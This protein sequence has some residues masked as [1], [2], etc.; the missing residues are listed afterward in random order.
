MRHIVVFGTFDTKGAEYAYLI[1]RIRE[2]FDGEIITVDIAGMPYTP[3][4]TPTI[5]N[6]QAAAL[7]GYSEADLHSADRLGGVEIMIQ[8]LKLVLAG[9]Y[10]ERRMDGV[11][12]LG[13]GAGTI[14]GLEAMKSL[15]AGFP[16]IM[17]ST[18]ATSAKIGKYMEGNDIMVMNSI[19]DIAG[20]NQ[21]SKKVF[22]I[23]A[24][25]IAGSV[26]ASAAGGKD[27]EEKKT[28]IAATMYGNTTAGVTAAKER[29]EAYGY[30]VLVF[31]A[32]GGGGR[33]LE[34]LVRA[35]LIDG[36]LDLTTTEWADNMCEG[37]ACA[38]GAERLDAG[39]Q[40]GI[41]QVVAPGALDQVNY[42]SREAIP[43]KYA[44]RTIYGEG[45]SCLMRTNVEENAKMG[46]IIAGKL[47][48]CA[49]PCVFLF[50]NRGY[51]KLDIKE[52]PFYGPAENKAFHDAFI[53]HI[54]SENVT[55]KEYDLHINDEAFGIIAA[56]ELHKLICAA[57]K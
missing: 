10:R 32:N 56:E 36:I 47:N 37:S 54:R 45:R 21:I 24:G 55:V 41:P 44:G 5:S 11:I 42:G 1:D 46:E 22:R 50:P 43:A 48:Q 18:I 57:G 27:T 4:F 19:V 13:G 17:V 38:G 53:A 35:G 26:S 6:L 52:G 12:A 8:A 16:K 30:E 25:A 49:A 9:L 31:H 2:Q 39:A 51:S 28:T 3:P 7:A 14:M 15:P 40:C 23:A 33:T 20:I 29:L 34:A